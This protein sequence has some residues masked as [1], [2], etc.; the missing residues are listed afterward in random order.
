MRILALDLSERS[1]GFACWGEDDACIASG[2]WVLGSEYT[3]AGTVFGK[4]HEEMSNLNRVGKIDA[5]FWERPLALDGWNKNSN[6]NSH[7]LAVGLAAHAFSWAD[8]MGCKIARDV[9]MS[10]WRAHFLAGLSWNSKHKGAV[11]DTLK[12]MAVNRCRALGFRPRTHDEAEAIGILDHVCD[13]LQITPYWRKR[14]PLA[15]GR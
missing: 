11:T 3:S 13:T 2:R 10:T 6:A 8:F 1:S 4:L 7:L 14:A 12:E 15:V 9:S 5:V